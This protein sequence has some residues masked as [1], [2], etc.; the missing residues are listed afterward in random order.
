MTFWTN[1]KIA[2]NKKGRFLALKE[3]PGHTQELSR[4][5]DKQNYIASDQL[6]LFIKFYENP[7]CQ[8]F[9]ICIKV[10]FLAIQGHFGAFLTLK[11]PLEGQPELCRK[12]RSVTFLLISCLKFVQNFKKIQGVVFEKSEHR[13]T[14]KERHRQK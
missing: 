9:A 10:P 2:K 5:T 6:Q 1:M 8:F 3:P 12:I 11:S 13:R 14:N 7:R 4:G